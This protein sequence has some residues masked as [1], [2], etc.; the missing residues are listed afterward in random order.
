MTSR[1]AAEAPKAP[2]RAQNARKIEVFVGGGLKNTTKHEV[3]ALWG[4]QIHDTTRENTRKIEVLGLSGRSNELKMGCRGPQGLPE[5]SKREKTHGFCRGRPQ[6]HEK[7]Q[8][9]CASGRGFQGLTEGSKHEKTRGLCRRRSQTHEK[10]RG[11]RASG[12]GFE[13]IPGPHRGLKTPEKS[14]FSSDEASKVAL[15]RVW[16]WEKGSTPFS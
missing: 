9:F 4:G 15:F 1:W 13:G 10:T 7:T 12:S 11:F 8:G 6:T 5:V 2:W 16:G 14:R 3:L